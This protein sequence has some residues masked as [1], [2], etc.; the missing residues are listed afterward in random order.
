MSGSDSE[1]DGKTIFALRGYRAAMPVSSNSKEQRLIENH[2]TIQPA[3][4]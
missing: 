4:G 3:Y 2:R 1:Y